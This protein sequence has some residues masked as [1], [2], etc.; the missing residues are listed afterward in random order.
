LV[1]LKYVGAKYEFILR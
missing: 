1:I